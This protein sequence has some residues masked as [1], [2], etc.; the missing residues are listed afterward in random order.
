MSGVKPMITVPLL[1]NSLNNY[2]INDLRRGPVLILRP[3]SYSLGTKRAKTGRDYLNM[4]NKERLFF[5]LFAKSF[6]T[7][8]TNKHNSL[9]ALR[10]NNLCIVI[11]VLQTP[12]E[13]YYWLE[14][15]RKT[16]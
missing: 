9:F 7:F 15:K 6:A 14:S 12:E 3:G 4:S 16:V 1:A 2:N 5:F 11:H 8:S 13:P 10:W